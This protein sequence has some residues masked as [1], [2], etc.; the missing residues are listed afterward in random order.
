[1]VAYRR[2]FRKVLQYRV[3]ELGVVVSRVVFRRIRVEAGR[4]VDSSSKVVAGALVV[5]EW[6]LN[7]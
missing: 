4:V 7:L 5:V 2:V 3:V 1:L 6:A